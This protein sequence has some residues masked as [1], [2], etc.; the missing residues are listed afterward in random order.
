MRY[1]L[2][3]HILVGSSARAEWG[4]AKTVTRKN[5]HSCGNGLLVSGNPVGSVRCLQIK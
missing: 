2:V 3:I 1:A 4:Y 5:G